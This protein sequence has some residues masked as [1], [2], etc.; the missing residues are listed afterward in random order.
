MESR[1]SSSYKR[2]EIW[3]ERWLHEL[4]VTSGFIDEMSNDC[5][6]SDLGHCESAFSNGG[7]DDGHT[8]VGF[9]LLCETSFVSTAAV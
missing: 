6:R 3:T 7:S 9:E 4:N 1:L 2:V 8:T 5:P